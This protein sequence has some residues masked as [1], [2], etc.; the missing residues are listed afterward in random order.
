MSTAAAGNDWTDR[1]LRTLERRLRLFKQRGREGRP[2]T[3]EQ[4]DRFHADLGT[5]A[6]EI[7]KRALAESAGR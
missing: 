5:V 2:P 1:R 3:E 7:E 6:V 4:F